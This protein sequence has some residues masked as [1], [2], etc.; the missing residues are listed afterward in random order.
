MKFC[1]GLSK[2]AE[3]HMK[4]EEYDEALSTLNKIIDEVG[5]GN[6]YYWYLRGKCH[7]N[8]GPTHLHSAREDLINCHRK[9]E[10]LN[11]ENPLIMRFKADYISAILEVEHGC[12]L[13]RAEYYFLRFLEVKKKFDKY[14]IKRDM[15]MFE[16]MITNAEKYLQ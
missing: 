13:K 9:L 10:K 16:D 6:P 7:S 2:D 14:K 5:S 3:K 12:D 11:G 15:P 4:K 8:M 1:L